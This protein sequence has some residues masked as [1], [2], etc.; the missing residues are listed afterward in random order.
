[1]SPFNQKKA[2]EDWLEK[3]EK[4][5]F[6]DLKRDVKHKEKLV[7]IKRK[8]EVAKTRTKLAKARTK[9]AEARTKRRTV[10]GLPMRKVRQTRVLSRKARIR[11]I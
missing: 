9:L 8:T 7:K 11:L 2:I 4:K 6:E 1:M 3:R 10:L 5:E